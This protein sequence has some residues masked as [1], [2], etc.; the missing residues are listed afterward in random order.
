MNHIERF[1]AVMNFQRVDRLPCVEWSPWWDLTIDRWKQEGLPKELDEVMDIARYFE[2]D[3]Y[4]MF[5]VRPF[6]EVEENQHHY[7]GLITN[8]D[9]Y[10]AL[11]PRLYPARDEEFASLKRW[12]KAE[13][14]GQVVIWFVLDGFFWFPRM[15]LGNERHLYAFYDQ[16]E[17]LHLMNRDIA[18]YNIACIH[19]IC[20]VCKP[21]FMIFAE[22]M[23]YNHGPMLSRKLF[24][25]FLRPYYRQLIPVLEQYDIMPFV[26]CDGDVTEMVP[27]LQD[28]GVKG[29]LPLERQ[30]GVDAKA[31]RK[32]FPEFRMIG[33]YDKMVVP[34]GEG[35]MRA[36]FERLLPVMKSGG[37]IPSMDHQT[38][39]GVSLEQYRCYIRLLR[40][41]SVL[42][43]A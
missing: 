34:H 13:R 23:A 7:T 25:E 18:E 29:V 9:E 30:S 37:F 35:A 39:P 27:W 12:A 41:Y 43:A 1:R 42:A 10:R 40:E 38:P 36:E 11:L 14:E 15:L 8:M 28:A 16:P 33:H 6:A 17:L 3:P 22:D 21:V 20:K 32:S 2:L 5:W 26:D 4:Y 19:K 24:D 31:L